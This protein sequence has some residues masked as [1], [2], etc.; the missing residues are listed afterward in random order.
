MSNL[1]ECPLKQ[2]IEIDLTQ[3]LITFIQHFYH[4]SSTHTDVLKPALNKLSNLRI[5]A[6][7]NSLNLNNSSLN[8]LLSYHSHVIHLLTKLP[9]DVG[10]EFSYYTIF[11][12]ETTIASILP[13][14]LPISR[15]I[16]YK[17]LKY[18][19]FSILF[20]LGTLNL[21]LGT[22]QIRNSLENIKLSI[23]YFQSS[24]GT[25]NY[26]KN[27]IN[28]E[29]EQEE[30]FSPDL[31]YNCIN[32]LEFLALSQAQECVWQTA[33]MEQ[34][35]NGTIS[36]IAAEVSRLYSNTL[37]SIN[38]SKHTS[39][40]WI[41]FNFPNTWIKHIKL[42]IAHFLAVSQYR[43]SI[44]DLSTNEYGIEVG[45]LSNAITTLKKPLQEI[46]NPPT[47][48]EKDSQN[49]LNK[50]IDT[51]QRAKRDND[52]IYLQVVPNFDDL[53]EIK[54]S[55]MVKSILPDKLNEEIIC[56]QD[57]LDYKVYRSLN[58]Y[59]ERK[60]D[61]IN[62]RLI[63]KFKETDDKL[64]QTFQDL[65]L[66]DSLHALDR[67]INL[68]PSL[69]RNSEELRN[70]EAFKTLQELL[71]AVE[72]ASQ[73]NTDK[74]HQVS[75]S[76]DDEAEEDERFRIE[77]GTRVW[78]RIKS[79]ESNKPIREREQHL[80]KTIEFARNSDQ[81]VKSL[82]NE[83][84]PFIEILSKDEEVIKKSIP[85]FQKTSLDKS[86]GTRKLKNLID[87]LNDLKIQ[88]QRTLQA[89]SRV[90][91][92]DQINAKDLSNN[93]INDLEEFFDDRLIGWYGAL[94]EQIIQNQNHQDKLLNELDV[95]NRDFLESQKQDPLIRSRELKFE[96]Y[97]MS[98]NKFYEILQMLNEGL[99]FHQ[100]FFKILE[101]LEE[102]TN[103]FLEKRRIE[104][105]ELQKEIEEG[106]KGN[107]SGSKF[108]GND[109]LPNRR[110]STK[111][112]EGRSISGS[113]NKK[114]KSTSKSTT[115]EGGQ[116]RMIQPGVYDPAVHGPIRFSD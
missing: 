56:L 48:A 53:P 70:Q 104:C 69:I 98:Y 61:W 93:T 67:P 85:T 86:T 29:D 51:Y 42:K 113:T 80:L 62:N 2:T 27:L 108:I 79:E 90:S 15:P 33:T 96:T 52:L 82:Y 9:P 99:N 49:F 18:E 72:T 30:I 55:C 7:A 66:P 14:E 57:I 60:N 84:I 103:K 32:A 102:Q 97:E 75:K 16:S 71:K 50:L 109:E 28:S 92:K 83:W 12:T 1:L 47:L 115:E 10:I 74:L 87:E 17:N 59:E 114:S 73:K 39:G 11:P 20:N 88:R 31:S 110:S 19:R 38:D 95:V 3:P 105:I 106:K 8:V 6:Q 107:Q 5:Q 64:N 112:N 54:P 21:N 34:K 40:P 36:R 101:Q 41:G 58:I 13:G 4:H 22:K 35:R 46:S 65:N 76:L 77:Y 78:N 81:T 24:A 44:D 89:I 68:P 25:F 26:L 37:H 91:I 43:K 63:S 94:E 45:R 116:R 100:E 23:H 111:V